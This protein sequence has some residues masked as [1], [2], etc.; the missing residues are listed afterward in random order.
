MERKKWSLKNPKT[1][2]RAYTGLETPTDDYLEQHGIKGMKW[3]VRRTPEQLGHK[4]G[5]KKWR[6]KVKSLSEM[7][8]ESYQK[9]KAKLDA[10]DKELRRKEELKRQQDEIKRREEALKPK[11]DSNEKSRTKTTIPKNRN[12]NDL[13]DEELRQILS[14]HNMEEQYKKITAGQKTR[15]QRVADALIKNSMDIGGQLLKEYTKKAFSEKIEKALIANG[16]LRDKE[17]EQR[18]RQERERRERE[19]REREERERRNNP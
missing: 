9:K 3:G 16:V 12:V 1:N 13:S 17:A 10:K 11:D 7:K 15:G 14:R 5:K 8:E 19:Q 18:E 2:P 4:T 6:I